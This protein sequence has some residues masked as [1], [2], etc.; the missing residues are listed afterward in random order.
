MLT[1]A[2]FVTF[3]WASLAALQWTGGELKK[4]AAISSWHQATQSARDRDFPRS[5]EKYSMA[6]EL[7]C[8][9]AKV[10]MGRGAVYYMHDDLENAEKDFAEA[11]R[12]EPS[13]E[14]L[15]LIRNSMAHVR[16]DVASTKENYTEAIKFWTEAINID[17]KDGCAYLQIAIV[18]S[19]CSKKYLRDGKEAVEYATKACELSNWKSWNDVLVLSMAYVESKDLEKAIKWA[20]RSL[21]LAP[22]SKKQ[23]AANLIDIVHRRMSKRR[24]GTQT[25][26]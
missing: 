9:D 21:D 6:I 15:I 11:L 4:I 8:L 5:I 13:A 26:L 22:E 23:I 2:L 16:A 12:R 17:P 7:G 20:R 14:D 24:F 25:C 19:M 10:Y 3:A 1:I 18:K